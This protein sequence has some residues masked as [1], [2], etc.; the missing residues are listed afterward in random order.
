MATA[1]RVRLQGGQPSRWKR[2]MT[3]LVGLIGA[4]ALVL[5]W[6]ALAIS[7]RASAAVA[8]RAACVCH[9]ISQR[10]LDACKGEIGEDAGPVM[11]SAESENRTV[12]AR[13]LIFARQ[14]ARYDKANGCVLERW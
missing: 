1:K 6:S 10:G 3:L 12:T 4:I 9:Y 2:N 11:L 8:A 14:T 7:G 13:Y 5:G